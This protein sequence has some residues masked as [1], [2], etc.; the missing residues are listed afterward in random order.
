MS[1]T[2]S[3]CFITA[4]TTVIINSFYPYNLEYMNKPLEKFTSEDL[5]DYFVSMGM[6]RYVHL[7]KSDKLD[8][9]DISDM[10]IE[11]LKEAGI[12]SIIDQLKIFLAIQNMKLGKQYMSKAQVQPVLQFLQSPS[13]PGFKKYVPSFR[14]HGVTG[15]ILLSDYCN[16]SILNEIGVESVL[17]ASRIIVFFR[18]YFENDDYDHVESKKRLLSKISSLCKD[19]YIMR[20]IE[21]NDV[22]HRMLQEGGQELLNEIGIEIKNLLFKKIMK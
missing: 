6:T 1:H 3:I 14:K 22:S 8:V 12:D 20:R 4:L 10:D 17:D 11:D 2:D 18:K 7:I 16:V 9:K 13:L 21:K 5:S 15:E 19:E